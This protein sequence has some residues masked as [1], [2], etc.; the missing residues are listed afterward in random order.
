M[1]NKMLLRRINTMPDILGIV[2]RYN[3]AKYNKP[4]IIWVC[5]DLESE[6]VFLLD[7][8]PNIIFSSVE[9]HYV[10]VLGNCSGT[11]RIQQ[12]WILIS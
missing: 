5:Y 7:L 9:N 6:Q 12:H 4:N 8:P 2:Y 10:F 1:Q 11:I 3:V